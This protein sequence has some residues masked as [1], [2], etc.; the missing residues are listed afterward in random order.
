MGAVPG[1][2][3]HTDAVLTEFGYSAD[4]LAQLRADGAI[5]QEFGSVA[6]DQSL[7]AFTSDLFD[8]APVGGDGL[9]EDYDFSGITYKVYAGAFGAPCAVTVSSMPR[10]PFS[11][12]TRWVWSGR[13]AP[14][15]RPSSG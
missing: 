1:L 2:G 4:E 8:R 11:R 6:R 7:G 13:T 10:S 9:S 15:S 5:G 12:V 3:E 14:A